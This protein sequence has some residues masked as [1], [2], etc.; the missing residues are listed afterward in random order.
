[1]FPRGQPGGGGGK[2]LNRQEAK[3]LRMVVRKQDKTQECQLHTQESFQ[4]HSHVLSYDI[5]H[6]YKE[7]LNKF[8]QTTECWPEQAILIIILRRERDSIYE[9]A[10]SVHVYMFRSSMKT[11]N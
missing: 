7:R 5:G 2:I 8:G 11:A 1:M 4:W 3:S 6:S 9:V 10:T